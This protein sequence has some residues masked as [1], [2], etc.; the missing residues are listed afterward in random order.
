VAIT[1][2]ID[3]I[4]DPGWIALVRSSAD[5]AIFHHP[6]WLDLLRS[7]Y[8]YELR[9]CCVVR[10]ARIEAGIPFAR[11]NS[12]LTGRR[13]VALPFSDVCTPVLA[14]D[15]DPSSLDALGEALSDEARRTGIG[16]TIHSSLPGASDALIR[17]QFVQHRLPLSQD[18][19]EVERGFSKSR[20][21]GMKKAKRENLRGERRT[22]ASALDAFYSLHLK[23]RR[24]L[25][26]PTQPKRFIARFEQ[27][28]DEGL[29]FVWLVHD[30]NH[31]IAAAVFLT[32]NGTVTY[33]YG[34][35][36]PRALD[37]R[38]NNLLFWEAILW[39]CGAGFDTFDFGRTDIDNDGLRAFK[40]GWGAEETEL[41]YTYLLDRDPQLEPSLRD[42]VLSGTIRRSPAIVGRLVGETLYRHA[43]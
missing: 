3:P 36:H 16:L 22:D 34:A 18:V 30:E 28:F 5:A 39:S 8:R 33:K 1:R 43:A 41:S 7:Q 25:G 35:S 17:P 26:V 37:K 24:R 11:V 32:H 10:G 12:R 9:A 27:L 40:K 31:P 4:E 14:P 29:G 15:A 19:T 42:R 21:R 6:S 2:L 13:L 20:T 38:P 23:T